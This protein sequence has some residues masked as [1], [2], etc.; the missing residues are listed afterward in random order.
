MLL[1]LDMLFFKIKLLFLSWKMAIANS[2][3]SADRYA[4]MC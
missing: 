2:Q 3:H 1:Y 4:A